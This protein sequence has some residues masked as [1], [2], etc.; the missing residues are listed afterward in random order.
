MLYTRRL[1]RSVALAL[2]PFAISFLSGCTREGT[3][4]NSH[5]DAVSQAVEGSKPQAR[6]TGGPEDFDTI[7][8][9]Y[10]N[11][12]Y[13]DYGKLKENTED[14]RRFDRFLAWQ[15]QADLSAMSHPEQIAFYINAYNACCIK[16]ILDHYPVKTPQDI[17]GF[18]DQLKFEV[19]GESLTINQIESD[20]LIAKYRD[21]RAHF[22][23]VCSDR[24]CL[25]LKP[26]AYNGGELDAALEGT[27]K[28]FVASPKHFRVDRDK[29]V[30]Y[31]SK[32]F[33]WHGK[34]F[35]DDEKRAVTE[36]RPELYLRPWLDEEARQLLESGE[37]RLEFIDWDWTL[38]EN[39][40]VT[41]HP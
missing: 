38:N 11:G 29:K 36:N 5:S 13:F 8:R 30:V 17:A 19:A 20:R 41:N 22:A 23:I 2:L 4:T 18:F 12:D 10:V 40:A 24:S 37:Y 9:K 7:L 39:D 14:S 15:G 34:N 3:A 26:G 28:R 35:L 27:A 21:M 33:D 25:P 16:G 6:A 32:I 31:V 1:C